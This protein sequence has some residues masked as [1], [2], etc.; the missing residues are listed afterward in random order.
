MVA[1]IWKAHAS[2]ENAARYVSYFEARVAPELT[3]IAGYQGAEVLVGSGPNAEIVVITRWT[4]LEAVSAFAGDDIE[5]AVV[6]AD[7]AALLSD[8]DRG[9]V[10]RDVAFEHRPR[11]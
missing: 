9:V 4:S 7:A 11:G 6:H 8:Y 5:A 10:H 1:R 2:A 3:A